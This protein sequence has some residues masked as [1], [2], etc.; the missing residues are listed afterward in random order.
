MKFVKNDIDLK[1]Y[2]MLHAEEFPGSVQ[3][4]FVIANGAGDVKNVFFLFQY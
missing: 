4:V 3:H 1:M 2:S